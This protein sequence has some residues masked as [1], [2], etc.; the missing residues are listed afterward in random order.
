[1]EN[2]MHK[3]KVY[4]TRQAFLITRLVLLL[5]FYTTAGICQTPQLSA[6]LHG[7][8]VDAENG[9]PIPDVL[10][11][12]SAEKIEQVYPDRDFA[13]A[14]A[15]DTEGTFSLTI[16]NEPETYY[17]FSLM[18]L[19]PE[20]QSKLLRQE[21]SPGKNRYDLGEIALKRTLSL[22][23][24]VSGGM[25]VQ[26]CI[27][28]LKMH[29]KSAD[30]FRAAAPVEHGAK[31][32]A[33]GNFHF[34][35]LYPIEYTLTVSQ[36]GVIIAFVD[37]IHPQE[38]PHISIRLP[39]LK[40]LHGTVVDTE[41][42]PIAAAQ[43]YATRHRETPFGHN[44]LLASA[45][46]NDTGNFQMQVLETEAQYLS[47]EIS[48]RGYFSRVYQN[49]V[50]GEKPLTVP[51]E[52]GMTVK[53]HVILPED[54]DP[55][56][57]YT[58]KIFPAD[59]QMEPSL[60]PLVLY[61][62]LLSRHFPATASTFTVDGLFSGTYTFYIV[63]DGISATA[64][65][66]EASPNSEAVSIIADRP[67]STLQGHVRWADTGEP[68]HNAVVSRSWYPW[69]LNP[70][71]LSMTLDRFEVET[72]TDGNFKFDNLTE[73]PYQLY[74][75]AVHA[76]LETATNRYQRTRIHKQVEIP[77]PGTGYR[78]YLGKRDGTPFAE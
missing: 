64:I 15:T 26:G 72:D 60:N 65:N 20:Y 33:T 42:R 38:Q 4:A 57:H 2:T 74:I 37:A 11:R 63:G 45:Q 8:F 9:Q 16:P 44:A 34:S 71:D 36:N 51:L 39:K 73:K 14:T 66:V 69:E 55:A 3:L 75:R 18:A 52:K 54:I 5:C 23:G 53:G 67:T 49:V 59:T 62:P 13:H 6:S 41:A 30:F 58:V 24:N 32:D 70:S 77:I 12:A 10:V 35:D 17:A 31:I 56:A 21:M 50:I 47:L 46:T 61:K 25:E 1:M 22:Q 48:K 29:D 7:T 68:V 78:I 76:E 43:I 40:T 27:V 28:N 19:H